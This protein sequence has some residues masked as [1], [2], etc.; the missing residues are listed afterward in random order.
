[1]ATTGKIAAENQHVIM[2]A[3]EWFV[4]PYES[5]EVNCKEICVDDNY[6]G[7]TQGGATLDYTITP[8]VIEDDNG[9]LRKRFMVKGAAKMKTGLLTVDVKAIANLMSVGKVE[10]S[11]DG[12]KRTL[13]LGGGNAQL[14]RFV[15]VFRY[16]KDKEKGLYIYVGM[17]ATNTAPL[18]LAF[19]K[20][21]ET[22]M[23]LEYEA[24]T[25]G[26]DDTILVIEEDLQPA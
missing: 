19:T 9:R 15:V 4:K 18:S 3:G 13:K 6:A 8:Y 25:N 22:V 23:D 17:V 21:K 11:Q 7:E 1:M 20:D 12:T 14:K 16:P 10:D 24:D 2:G 5:G 26:V